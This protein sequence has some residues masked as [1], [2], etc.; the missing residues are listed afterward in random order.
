MS[1]L[2]GIL[3]FD[4][5]PVTS[6]SLT[7]LS[8]NLTEYGPDGEMTYFDGSIGML[9]RPFHTTAESRLERQPY[10][11]ASQAVITWNGR[12]DN[13][14]ELILKLGGN[15]NGDMTDVAIVAATFDRWGTD[16]FTKLAGDWSLAVWN[17]S[18]RELLL[19]RD[20]AGIRHLFYYPKA[21]SV[22]WSSHLKTLALCGD[23]FTLCDEYF[24]GYLAIWPEAHLT[25]YRELRAVPPGHFV[26]FRNRGVGIHPYWALS[27]TLE[28][29]YNT[30]SE[31]EEHFRH[32]FRQSV[33]RRLRTDS[34]ILADLSGGL[35][36][37]SIVC[38]ADDIIAK[39]GASTPRVDTFSACDRSD[40]EEDDFLY[41]TKVEQRRRR[42][43]YHAELQDDNST[44]LSLERSACFTATP[45]FGAR[46]ELKMI[47]AD[48]IARGKY[49]VLLSGTAGDELLGQ[50]LDPRVQIADLLRQFR[51][52][53]LAKQIVAWSLLLRRPWAHLLVD[54]VCLN[55]PV[56]IRSHI[57][58]SAVV[59]PW[60]NKAFARKHRL[61]V[62]Q[63]DVPKGSWFWLP[64]TRD[65]FHNLDLNIR[66]RSYAQPGVTETW[67]PYLDRNLVEF[68]V[69]IPTDQLLRPGQRRSLMRRSL[70]GFLPREIL[71]RKTK[72]TGSRYLVMT[73][74]KQW[75]KLEGVLKSPVIS[76]LGYVNQEQFYAAFLEAKRG[77]LSRNFV[78]LLR[79]LS[80]ELWLR[81]ALDRRV[82]SIDAM[83]RATTRGY[84]TTLES[85]PQ[86]RRN[87]L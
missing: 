8:Q 54:A 22:V 9:Y 73:L 3:N 52:V 72:S 48:V 78:R 79:A 42:V 25:P 75:S 57:T 68:L 47:K 34:P 23:Q 82:I 32:L 17:P 29:R 5:E 58:E 27:S 46:A 77:S 37:S 87:G 55:L 86:R 45:G 10:L 16:C 39:E 7:F 31:Y 19:A 44:S 81:D 20:Y 13:R 43:G 74:Q 38:M 71:L 84:E 85:V 62:R 26:R 51:L 69:S 12:L 56:S 11:T 18:H 35:D 61:S 41:F 66:E 4:G 40:P 2:A 60:I 65:L 6:E 50:A 36:S 64:S 30:D 49:R 21:R 28:T 70:V 76:R 80:W 15:G 83:D 53:G 24:A 63:L 1:V 59:D 14:E 67:C 33:R